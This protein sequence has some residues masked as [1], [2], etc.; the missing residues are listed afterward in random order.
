MHCIFLAAAEVKLE[1]TNFVSLEISPLTIR[2]V[3]TSPKSLATPPA[4][5]LR[6]VEAGYLTTAFH[7]DSLSSSWFA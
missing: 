1:P 5:H 3:Q 7:S 6:P 2:A 4:S